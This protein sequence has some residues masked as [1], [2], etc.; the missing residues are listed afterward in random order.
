MEIL[1]SM[2]LGF[3]M[4]DEKISGPGLTESVT[5]GVEAFQKSSVIEY[6]IIMLLGSVGQGR[7]R[8]VVRAAGEAVI[9]LFQA[10]Y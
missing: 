3:L 6:E 4:R 1:D 8:S 5:A 7:K 9:W 10:P 2:L